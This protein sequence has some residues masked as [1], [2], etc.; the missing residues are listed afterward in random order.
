VSGFSDSR[1]RVVVDA[2]AAGGGTGIAS[3]SRAMVRALASRDDIAIC[4]VTSS[5]DLFRDLPSGEI[6]EAPRS[7][8]GFI[9]RAA[10][11]EAALPRILRRARADVLLSTAPEL[12]LRPVSVPS[13]IVVHDVAPLIAPA[14]FGRLRWGRFAADMGRVCAGA[15]IVICVSESTRLALFGA[16]RVSRTKLVVVGEGAGHEPAQVNGASA[17]PPE[18]FTVLWAGNLFRGDAKPQPHKNFAPLLEAIGQTRDKGQPVRLVAVGPLGR[19]ARV[20]WE[21]LARATGAHGVAE[22]LGYVTTAELDRLYRS[23]GALAYPSITEGFGLPVLE[24]FGRGTPVIASDIPAVR[25]V[26]GD[27]VLYVQR[28]LDADAWRD[29]IIQL[30]DDALLRDSL[31]AQGRAR[32][33]CFTWTA[34]AG[35]LVKALRAAAQGAA[36]PPEP[37]GRTRAMSRG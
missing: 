36:G 1:L 34:S 32:L 10:W 7:T 17:Q 18:V 19:R 13:V 9:R 4:L 15:A 8:V 22:H 23:A 33:R 25:E 6:V 16:V 29:A 28:V 12:P 37:R 26:A 5:I 3:Y 24:A 21:R 35:D 14:L 11:R 31:V 30:R 2:L 27:A 20:A